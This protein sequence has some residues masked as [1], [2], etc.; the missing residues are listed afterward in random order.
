MVA[1]KT[2]L[3][4]MINLHSPCSESEEATEECLEYQAIC[5]RCHGSKQIETWEG[6]YKYKPCPVCKGRGKMT[7]HVE[8]KWRPST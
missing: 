6:E 2:E 7:A 3:L 4:G 1:R 5:N 8:I